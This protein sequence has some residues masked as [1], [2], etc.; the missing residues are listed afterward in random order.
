M[1]EKI[2]KE[3]LNNLLRNVYKLQKKENEKKND[4][5]IEMLEKYNKNNEY[6]YFEIYLIEMIPKR[7]GA[8][9]Y[10]NKM[11]PKLS[12]QEIYIGCLKG[13]S[14]YLKYRDIILYQNA[15]IDL[16]KMV[17][18]NINKNIWYLETDLICNRLIKVLC[19]MNLIN[20]KHMLKNCPIPDICFYPSLYKVTDPESF[21]NI[22]NNNSD[23]KNKKVFDFIP[24]VREYSIRNKIILNNAVYYL[25]DKIKLVDKKCLI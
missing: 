22:I 1:D 10:N 6:F 4:N 8:V 2:Q 3:I 9:I 24:Y 21:V 5:V 7:N 16:L 11:F 25:Y 20:M 18:P 19:R 13:E 17:T 15:N 12:P 14:I 23:I